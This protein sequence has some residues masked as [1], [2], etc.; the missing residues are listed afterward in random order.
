MI[1]VFLLVM[2]K[3][4]KEQEIIQN[5]ESEFTKLYKM[6]EK[7]IE[8]IALS[9]KKLE[10]ERREREVLQKRVKFLVFR[11]K[12]LVGRNDDSAKSKARGSCRR[13]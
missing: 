1:L 6:L 3:P 2:K 5:E 4:P 11:L 7:C 12:F 13:N 8:E 10:E 9:N